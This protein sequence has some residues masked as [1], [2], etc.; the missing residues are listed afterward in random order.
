[1]LYKMNLQIK[2]KSKPGG[3]AFIRLY[4]YDERGQNESYEITENRL[5]YI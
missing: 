1:M 5:H 4:E 2:L 3:K